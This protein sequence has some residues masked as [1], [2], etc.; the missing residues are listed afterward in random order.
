[1]Y[2]NV[3]LTIFVIVQ[4]LTI[5]LVYKWWDKYG[6]DLFKTFSSFNQNI[7][8][9]KNSFSSSNPFGQIPD[10]NEMFKQINQMTKKMTN[11]K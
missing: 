2:L 10:M 9:T 3:I 11:L 8:T 6:R 4:V 7:S 5:F 1:M